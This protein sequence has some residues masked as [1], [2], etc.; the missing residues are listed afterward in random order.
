[1]ALSWAIRSTLPAVAKG[2]QVSLAGADRFAS[3]VLPVITSFQQSGVTS[4]RQLAIALNNR[5][6]RTARGGKRQVSNVR[7]VLARAGTR[8]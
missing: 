4:L 7:N 2:R 1:M 8:L 5:G 3:Q 6:V